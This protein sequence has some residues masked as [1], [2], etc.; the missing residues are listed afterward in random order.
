[1]GNYLGQS[2]EIYELSHK[3][4]DKG[5]KVWLKGMPSCFGRK[6][7]VFTYYFG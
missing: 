7:L 4:L 5:K 1:M 6:M 2:F 3:S